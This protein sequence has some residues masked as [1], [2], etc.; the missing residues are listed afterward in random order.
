M[1]KAPSNHRTGLIATA[2]PSECVVRFGELYW[3]GGEVGGEKEKRKVARR[4]WHHG[5]RTNIFKSSC[6]AV[7]DV[8]QALDS[9]VP[10]W[11]GVCVPPQCSHAASPTCHHARQLCSPGLLF[12]LLPFLHSHILIFLHSDE[13]YSSRNYFSP[14]YL[15]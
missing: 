3:F 2:Y 13:R 14:S 15:W 1:F 6:P 4:I 11:V 10:D 7:W 9:Q 8:S 5:P 12:V